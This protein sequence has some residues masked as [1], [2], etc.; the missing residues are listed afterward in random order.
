MGGAFLKERDLG[1][2]QEEGSKAVWPRSGRPATW[3]RRFPQVLPDEAG[4]KA[5]PGDGPCLPS[6]GLPT[7]R[8]FSHQVWEGAGATHRVCS[9]GR[10]W[11]ADLPTDWIGLS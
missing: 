6:W 9:F 7:H 2:E 1:W 4:S 3:P 11:N 10:C 5:L 8:G